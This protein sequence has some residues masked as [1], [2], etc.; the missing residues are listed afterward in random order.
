MPSPQLAD[1]YHPT[2]SLD[3]YH[4]PFASTTN[5]ECKHSVSGFWGSKSL[6]SNS[7]FQTYATSS[8]GYALPYTLSQHLPPA[9][10]THS[11]Y[12][13]HELGIWLLWFNT[14]SPPLD[15]AISGSHH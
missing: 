13:A 14:L 12:R 2:H 4:Q 5:T 9:I 7:P 10:C 1:R 8:T 3:A 11:Q 15:L 6:L